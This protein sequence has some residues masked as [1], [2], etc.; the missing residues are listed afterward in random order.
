MSET[1]VEKWY[2]TIDTTEVC[3]GPFA[4]RDKAIEYGR[5]EYGLDVEFDVGEGIRQPPGMHVPNAQWVI[6]TTAESASDDGEQAEDYPDVSQEAV[7]ELDAFLKA[8]GEKYCIAN[9]NVVLDWEKIP[10]TTP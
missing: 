9:Y 7:D 2:A 8:W 10:A 6:E 4:S 3:A 5:T 1:K